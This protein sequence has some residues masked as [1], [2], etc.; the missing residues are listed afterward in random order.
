MFGIGTPEEVVVLGILAL[1]IVVLVAGWRGNRR[2][3][4]S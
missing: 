2:H 4:G 3:R 1:G